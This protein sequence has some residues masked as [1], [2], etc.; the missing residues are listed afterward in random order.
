M[1]TLRGACFPGDRAVPSAWV[2]D[3]LRRLVSDAGDAQA[4]VAEAAPAF[5][6]QVP[7][8]SRLST[9]GI[10]GHLLGELPPIQ[11]VPYV[12]RRLA[13]LRPTLLIVEDVHWSDASGIEALVASARDRHAAQRLGLEVPMDLLRGRGRALE[14]LGDLLTQPG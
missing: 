4:I 13:A 10:R 5:A 9:T 6:G 8:L 7:E 14:L 3:M 1:R 11:R 12:L 2:S